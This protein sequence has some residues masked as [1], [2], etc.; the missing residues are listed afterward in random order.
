VLDLGEWIWQLDGPSA[1]RR[2]ATTI[3]R[4]YALARERFAE[5]GVETGEALER[6]GEV[7]ISMQCWQGDD[8]RGF[9]GEG[10]SELGGG[11]A[12]TGSYKGR[13]R[14]PAELRMD[15]EHALRLI[16]GKHRFALHASYGEF[17]RREVD[18]DAI[19]SEH[20]QGWIEWAKTLGLGLDFN[21]TFF[22]HR[23][24]ESGFTL[25]HRDDGVRGFWVEHGRRCREIG[26][27]MGRALGTPCVTNLW[28]PDGW[29]DTT[30]DR[31]GPRERLIDSLDAIYR[32]T[33]TARWNV[34]C[35]EGK[36]FGLGSE[37]YV[38]GSQEFY[39][40]YAITRKKHVCLDTGHYHPTESVADKITAVMPW[41]PGVL[42]H[43]SR[44]IRWDSDHVVTLGDE[45][46]GLA[47]EL[48]R[49]G[50]VGSGRLH[51]GLDYF[52][53]S[54][55]RVAAWVIGARSLM[56]ALLVALLEPTKKLRELEA[57]ADLTGRLAWMEA[58]KGLPWGA[59][60]DWHCERQGVMGEGYWL[61]EIR[62]YERD[63]LARRG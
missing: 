30:A 25:A 37:S 4:T 16:P 36:L 12:V 41:V 57:E 38:V 53:A 20:F 60:W 58:V 1:M 50:Y 54:I 63:V 13:A 21:P 55:N 6:L 62:R 14:T 8:V 3:E 23:L 51:L 44:G 42:L 7:A 40:G 11:L 18:R 35:V 49:G 28:I 32:K 39:L 48:V 19:G 61:G 43:V 27:A 15:F 17:G 9:E 10:V 2:R 24:A 5:L 52:D 45:L 59:V 56:K 22:S 47:S 46:V 26:A 29:K 33:I 31:Q 34:D